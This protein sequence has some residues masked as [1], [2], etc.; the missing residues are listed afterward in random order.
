MLA[1][2]CHS[3][4]TGAGRTRFDRGAEPTLRFPNRMTIGSSA[5]HTAIDS[6]MPMQ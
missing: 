6:N 2:R 3:S 1:T 5:L 4:V